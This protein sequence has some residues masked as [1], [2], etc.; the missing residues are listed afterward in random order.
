EKAGVAKASLYSHFRSKEEI[1]LAYLI[2]MDGIL[3]KD[4]RMFLAQQPRGKANILAIFDFLNQFYQREGFRG[5]WCLNTISEIP[6][7]NVRIKAEII[8]Q[9]KAFMALLEGIVRENLPEAPLE[10]VKRLSRRIYLL[11]E[12]AIAE[13]QLQGENWPIAEAKQMME[14][15]LD[16]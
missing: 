1:C 2:R 12:G 14:G 11:Y 13:S 3:V 9:K 4:L 8:R 7:D 16:W 10:R 15:M 6:R 5:C